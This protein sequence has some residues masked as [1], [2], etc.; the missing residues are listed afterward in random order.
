MNMEAPDR[1]ALIEAVAAEVLKRLRQASEAEPIA[2]KKQAVLLAAEPA[3]ALRASSSRIMTC[4][5]T[6]SRSETAICSSFRRHA[7]SCCPTWPMALA[8][9]RASDLR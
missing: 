5:I 1:A 2:S 3:P 6:T 4:V 8:Q 9:A 7:S